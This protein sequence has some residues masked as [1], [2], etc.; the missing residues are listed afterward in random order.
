MIED[1]NPHHHTNAHIKTFTW[2]PLPPP[3]V[4]SP[5]TSPWTPSHM[6]AQTSV[7]LKRQ[8]RKLLSHLGRDWSL[9]P[10]S[11]QQKNSSTPSHM[12]AKIGL[13][14]KRQRRKLLSLLQ[15]SK[16][17]LYNLSPPPQFSLTPSHMAAQ[18]GLSLKWQSRKKLYRL[19]F[20]PPTVQA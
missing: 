18:T 9:P 11:S 16:L 6:A 7:A 4:P 12:A 2:S 13:A 8:R 10:V 3:T 19:F 17:N 14:L 15:T 1:Q 5:H 20:T